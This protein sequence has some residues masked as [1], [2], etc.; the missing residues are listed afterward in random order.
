MLYNGDKSYSPLVCVGQNIET[1]TGGN[2]RC[3]CVSDSG[4]IAIVESD[5]YSAGESTESFLGRIADSIAELRKWNSDI[6]DAVAADFYYESEGQSAYVSD[7]M[8]RHGYII[9]SQTECFNASIN[10]G[11]AEENI[12]VVVAADNDVVDMRTVEFNCGALAESGFTF[13]I[14]DKN[15]VECF[16]HMSF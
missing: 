10:R 5:P 15:I 9:Y 13:S 14:V 16:A 8:A 3:L 12:L 4:R 11:L 6:I 7:I 2:I 1:E